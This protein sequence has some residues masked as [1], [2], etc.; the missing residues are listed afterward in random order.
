V[1]GFL[2]VIVS[3]IKIGIEE[4]VLNIAVCNRLPVRREEIYA[5]S[6]NVRETLFLHLYMNGRERVL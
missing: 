6:V 2:Y 5:S 1:E 3:D 4:L